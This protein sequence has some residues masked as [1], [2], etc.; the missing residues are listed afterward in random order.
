MPKKSVVGN[1]DLVEAKKAR[2]EDVL[3]VLHISLRGEG[4]KR[5]GLCPIPSHR[6]EQTNETFCVHFGEQWF[7]CLQCRKK[8]NVLDFATAWFGGMQHAGWWLIEVRAGTANKDG[9]LG[10]GADDVPDGGVDRD[11]EKAQ[12]KREIVAAVYEER[13]GGAEWERVA[14]GNGD[15]VLRELDQKMVVAVQPVFLDLI[16]Q[17]GGNEYDFSWVLARFYVGGKHG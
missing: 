14:E 8:G 11:A 1:A 6:G 17:H 2:F 13:G 3:A 10:R 4:E 9:V 5:T 15:A 16:R 7:S 12:L